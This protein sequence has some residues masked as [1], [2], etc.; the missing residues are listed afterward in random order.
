MKPTSLLF[1][2]ACAAT[3]AAAY[4]VP[5]ELKALYSNLTEHNSKCRSY[6]KNRKNLYDGHGNR[7]WGFC[8]DIPGA[9][10]LRGPKGKLGDMDVDCESPRAPACAGTNTI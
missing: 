1:A 5:A 6:V 10:Y 4:E 2:L 7:G 8:N 9:M 3:G